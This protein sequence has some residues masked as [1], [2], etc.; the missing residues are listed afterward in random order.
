MPVILTDAID[1]PK[2]PPVG[3]YRVGWHHAHVGEVITIHHNGGAAS[4]HLDQLKE[5]LNA[6]VKLV[7]RDRIME[8]LD[9]N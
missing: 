8:L 7:G 5:T 3:P 4:I 9:G 1:I 6:I 2:R